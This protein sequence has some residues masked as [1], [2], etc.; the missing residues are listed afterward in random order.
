MYESE[1]YRAQNEQKIQIQWINKVFFVFSCR[2]CTVIKI[3]SVYN[4][5]GGSS[6]PNNVWITQFN[7]VARP[8]RSKVKWHSCGQSARKKK[9]RSV[10][11]NENLFQWL[12]N[13]RYQNW[14]EEHSNFA[15]LPIFTN[16]K[17]TFLQKNWFK[18]YFPIQNWNIMVR[19]FVQ[20][21]EHL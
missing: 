11:W 8:L 10:F 19:F 1:F 17:K 16:K 14:T 6:K 7:H 13:N 15:W 2:H 18:F 9:N 21:Y 5:R 20:K 12:T 3:F 4:L